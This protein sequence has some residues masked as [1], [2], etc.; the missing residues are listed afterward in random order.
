[1]FRDALNGDIVGGAC[2]VAIKYFNTLL[3]VWLATCYSLLA[4][5]SN[6]ATLP[7]KVG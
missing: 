7:T 1:M 2:F 5:I 6:F 3:R 4:L